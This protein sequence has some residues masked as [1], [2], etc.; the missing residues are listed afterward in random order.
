MKYSMLVKHF[1][2][3]RI[4]FDILQLFY[5]ILLFGSQRRPIPLIHNGTS[6]LKHTFLI[7]LTIAVS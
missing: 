6:L 5:D 7:V 4:L 3:I 1:E 2:R